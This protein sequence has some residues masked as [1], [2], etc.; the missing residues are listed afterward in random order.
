MGTRHAAGTVRFV[1]M[2]RGPLALTAALATI[3]TLAFAA[4]AAAKP[5]PSCKTMSA[6][7][8]GNTLGFPVGKPTKTANGAVT[9]CTYPPTG[10]STS[11]ALLRYQTGSTK[12]SFEAARETFDASG[13]PTTDLAGLGK[14]AY[15][16]TLTSPS[17]DTNTVVFLKG[18]TEVLVTA[19][20][21]MEQVRALAGKIAK[22][23]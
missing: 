2:R 23:V 16:S 3:A 9:V 15:T 11:S 8:V 20:A 13:Q 18:G 17:G 12:S 1:K 19:T 5:K 4:P 21:P 10:T 7:T 22:K 6:T 14:A